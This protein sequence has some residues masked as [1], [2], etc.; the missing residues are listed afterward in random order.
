MV[1]LIVQRLI[2]SHYFNA[3]KYERP[4]SKTLKTSLTGVP[5]DPISM[6]QD[7]TIGRN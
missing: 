7:V 5:S 2:Y 4:H 1:I 3:I 6:C